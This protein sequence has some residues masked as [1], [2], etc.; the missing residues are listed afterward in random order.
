MGIMSLYI[1]LAVYPSCCIS[2]LLYIPL[3]VYPSYIPLGPDSV[4]GAYDWSVR[5]GTSRPEQIPNL[6]SSEERAM[7]RILPLL[8]VIIALA[9]A[10]LGHRAS[11]AQ[12]KQDKYTL[13]VPG[14]LAFS[15]FKGWRTGRL[16]A[17]VRPAARTRSHRLHPSAHLSLSHICWYKIWGP[18][19]VSVAPLLISP[20]II[21]TVATNGQTPL[22][23][24][25]AFPR[26]VLQ[27]RLSIGPQMRAQ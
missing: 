5:F 17:R 16:S 18:V 23:F 24:H 4:C 6:Q 13:K 27:V 21:G 1:P 25:S 12:D 22:S 14:G 3:A 20:L 19:Q 7:K 11:S 15:E 9:L 8:M 10:V 26:I 2:L